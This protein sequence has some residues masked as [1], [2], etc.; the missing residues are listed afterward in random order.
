MCRFSTVIEH[1]YKLVFM[2]VYCET[3]TVYNY[4]KFMHIV[5]IIFSLDFIFWKH[6][7]AVI[8]YCTSSKIRYENNIA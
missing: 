8:E 6:C 1:D 4:A 2:G 5:N 7:G 3:T